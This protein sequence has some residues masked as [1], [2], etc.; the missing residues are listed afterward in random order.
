[1]IFS[2]C[3]SPTLVP[4]RSCPFLSS[5]T[6]FHA[7]GNPKS[8]V[9]HFIFFLTHFDCYTKLSLLFI[10]SIIHFQKQFFDSETPFHCF[11]L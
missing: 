7:F 4:L 5:L 2:W 10:L 3:P 1:M 9:S 11:M 6:H 8:L